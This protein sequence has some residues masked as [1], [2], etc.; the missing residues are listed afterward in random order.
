MSTVPETQRQ[1]SVSRVS[2]TNF[3][4]QSKPQTQQK[5][6]VSSTVLQAQQSTAL[7]K[8]RPIDAAPVKISTA[9]PKCKKKTTT[10]LKRYPDFLPFLASP[11]FQPNAVVMD[12]K[13]VE[14]FDVIYSVKLFYFAA[15]SFPWSSCFFVFL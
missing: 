3:Q 2:S 4:A 10:V 12:I 6:D 7:A 5:S 15:I 8:P 9:V 14:N 13:Q 1:S 11:Q